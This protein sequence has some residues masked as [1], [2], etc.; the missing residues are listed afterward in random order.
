METRETLLKEI[1]RLKGERSHAETEVEREKWQLA[2]GCLYRAMRREDRILAGTATE[3][4]G[5]EIQDLWG[6]SRRMQQEALQERA[7]PVAHNM[8]ILRELMTLLEERARMQRIVDHPES[9][10]CPQHISAMHRRIED[11]TRKIRALEEESRVCKFMAAM[12]ELAAQMRTT[13]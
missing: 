7:S 8:R 6:Q 13:L 12:D 4:D 10:M 1:E 2:L 3:G 9:F 5:Q 11:V